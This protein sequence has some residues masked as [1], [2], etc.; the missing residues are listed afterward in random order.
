MKV[1]DKVSFESKFGLLAGVVVRVEGRKV[2]IKIQIDNCSY[3]FSR[4]TKDC[5][6]I[7]SLWRL[8]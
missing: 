5:K 2:E 6:V 7:D 8:E 1:K 3:T 4:S